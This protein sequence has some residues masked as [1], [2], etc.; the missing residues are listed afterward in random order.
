M[1]PVDS[2]VT[3]PEVLQI[4]YE[5]LILI[6]EGIDLASIKRRKRFHLA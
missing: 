2:A 4:T 6:I 3:N 1:P 5:Q